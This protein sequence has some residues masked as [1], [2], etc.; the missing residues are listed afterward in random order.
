MGMVPMAMTNARDSTSRLTVTPC[1][2]QA[3][4]RCSTSRSD[5]RACH[6]REEQAGLRPTRYLAGGMLVVPS[7]LG[8]QSRKHDDVFLPKAQIAYRW[9]PD[10]ADLRRG[11]ARLRRSG[12]FNTSFSTCRIRPDPEY[13]W[14]HEVGFKSSWFNASIS[15]HLAVLHRPERSAG[16]AGAAHREH[17]HPQRGKSRSM[18]LKWKLMLIIITEGHC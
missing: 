4:I 17:G 12:G 15:Q 5:R 10:F 18:A 14:N 2:G 1:S 6:R 9:T 8:H 7:E 13:S 11:V 3:T 16:D